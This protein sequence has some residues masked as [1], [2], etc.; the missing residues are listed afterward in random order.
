MKQVNLIE[1]KEDII[2]GNELII[3]FDFN[4]AKIEAKEITKLNSLVKMIHSSSI[5]MIVGHTDQVG[6]I[7]YNEH[8]SIKRAEAVKDWLIQNTQVKST[9]IDLK[10]KGESEL[11]NNGTNTNERALNRRVTVKVVSH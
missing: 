8:L 10:F 5:V 11:L 9:Q 4:L 3:Y 6:T 2:R 7:E 1:D